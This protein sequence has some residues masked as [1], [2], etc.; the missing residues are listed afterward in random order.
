MEWV[1]GMMDLLGPGR[2]AP[3]SLISLISRSIL[4]SSGGDEAT[5]GP[6]EWDPP[7][8]LNVGTS[9]GV[10]PNWPPHKSLVRVFIEVTKDGT[11]W[12]AE[13]VGS[14]ISG[15]ITRYR[16]ILMY[17]HAKRRCCCSCTN[18]VRGSCPLGSS[19][20]HNLLPPPVVVCLY[21]LQLL[22]QRGDADDPIYGRRKH[23]ED[24]GAFS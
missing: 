3:P 12:P 2:N 18:S 9:W 16:Q 13:P 23:P 6:D 22:D 5:G 15:I 7:H 10:S 17:R 21:S 1:N 8:Q 24:D 11:S 14:K 4:G 20:S 19:P